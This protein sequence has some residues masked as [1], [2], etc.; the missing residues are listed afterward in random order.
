[1]CKDTHVRGDSVPQ[2]FQQT[3]C[4]WSNITTIEGAFCGLTLFHT[5]ALQS[6]KGDQLINILQMVNFLISCTY[7]D[8]HIK[9]LTKTVW[10]CLSPS[11]ATCLVSNSFSTP[12]VHSLQL[13]FGYIWL[14]NAGYVKNVPLPKTKRNI[15]SSEWRVNQSSGPGW[16]FQLTGKKTCDRV[17]DLFAF[18]YSFCMNING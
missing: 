17:F 16:L 6:A 18:V 7:R 2:E 10:H 13:L 12:S 11:S 1:M 15:T 8:H 9:V 3:K 5:T 14:S 4:L